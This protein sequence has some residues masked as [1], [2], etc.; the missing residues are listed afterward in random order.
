MY[1]SKYCL[2]WKLNVAK[3]LHCRFGYCILGTVGKVWEQAP[4]SGAVCPS[5][6]K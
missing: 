1:A 5:D 3:V 4:E 2:K 6:G